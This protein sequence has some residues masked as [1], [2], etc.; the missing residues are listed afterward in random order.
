[1]KL[2]LNQKK[3][4]YRFLSEYVFSKWKTL[5]MSMVCTFISSICTVAVAS[6]V[7]PIIDDVFVNKNVYSLS[8]VALG[9]LFV[10]LMRGFGDYGEAIILNKLWQSIVQKIQIRCFS[11]LIKSDLEFFHT[12]KCGDL[13]SKLTNDINLLKTVTTTAINTLCKDFFVVIGIL[14][15]I[16]YRDLYFSIIAIIG[17]SATVLPTLKVGKKVRK[18]SNNTQQELSEWVSF[19]TQ[20]F[21]GIR[22]IKSYNMEKFETNVAKNITEN[23]LDL[24]VKSAKTKAIIHPT[25]EFLSGV[26]VSLI[27][28]IGGWLVINNYRTPGTLL[29]FLT[30]LIMIYR[31]IK[32]LAN[33][34]SL[35][36]EGLA[37]IGRIYDLIDMQSK[38]LEKSTAVKLDISQAN[39]TFRNVYFKYDSKEENVLSGINLSVPTGKSIAL[40]GHSG[41]GKSTLI[42]LIPRFYDVTSGSILIDNQNVKDVTIESLRNSISLVSQEI[43]LFND[44]IANNIAFGKMN[45]SIDEIKYAAKIAAALD[46]IEELP[47]KFNTQIGDNGVLLSGGQKQRISIARAILKNAPILL[48]DEATSALDTQSEHKIQTALTELMKGKTSIIVAHRLSTIVNADKILVLEKGRIIEEGSHK[49]LLELNGAYSKLYKAQHFK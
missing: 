7:K 16:L 32:S 10:S 1:M 29:S 26:A 27:V 20:S 47:E 24:S 3:I 9:F 12:S 8:G 42:N 17:F 15:L 36:Q 21:Q 22:M 4:L 11:H 40:V 45:S 14:G 39:I 6:L 38:I 13:V 28:F 34:N 30:A 41:S 5:A 33:S 19:L 2:K 46:F 31:P 23:I 43:I 35:L 18:I 25:I 37:A 48:L 49:E 44:S